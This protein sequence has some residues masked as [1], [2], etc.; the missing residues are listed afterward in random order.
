MRLAAVLLTLT[1]VAAGC[2]DEEPVWE[3]D[4][5]APDASDAS[6]DA[7]DVPGR[8]HAD[9]P[10]ELTGPQVHVFYVVAND[11]VDRRLDVDGTIARTV[12]AWNTWF[13]GQTG[14]PRLRVDTAGGAIDITFARLPTREAQITAE[15]PYVR[16]RLERDLRTLDLLPPGKMAAVYYDGGST[17]SCGGGPW[18]PELV[19]QVAAIYLQGTPPGAPACATQRLSADGVAMG[20][21]EFAMLHEIFHGLGAVPTCAPDHTM[22]GHVL[23]DPSDLMYTGSRPWRPTTLDIGRDD[24]WGHGRTTCLDAARSAFL[25]PLPDGAMLP[26]GW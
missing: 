24:Y 2:G 6:I 13:A 1:T 26:P 9:R 17:Y 22:R 19:G 18:P 3:P 12:T 25:D 8:A 5:G 20:Y 11:G 15:G 21:F 4:A 10:D 23:T 7:E 16:E 14:G